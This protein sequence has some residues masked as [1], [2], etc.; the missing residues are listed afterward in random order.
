MEAHMGLMDV[1]N[2]M[3][4]GPRGNANSSGMSPVTMAVIGLLAYKAL[5]SFTSQPNGAPAGSSQGAP[6]AQNASP[7]GGIGDILKGG[8]G[9]I[10]A[11]GAAGGVL[12][13]GL[14]DLLKQFQQAGQGGA[15]NSWVGSGPN[16]AISADDLTKVLDPDQIK[17]LTAHT[18]LSQ[19]QLLTALSQH[20]PEVVDQMTPDNRLP[21]EQ[22]VANMF[23]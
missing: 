17:T 3:Q 12:S 4:N 18:G 7:G 13:G 5:K 22:E 15:A 8:F 14:N 19:D 11:G 20:L 1:L 9:G 2:G 23:R 6:S 10:L 21:T 16:K